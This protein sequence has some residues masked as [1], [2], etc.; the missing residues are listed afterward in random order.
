MYT[1]YFNRSEKAIKVSKAK[2]ALQNL[3]FT[4]EVSK[5]NNCY[6]ICSNRN[7]LVEKAREIKKEWILELEDDLNTVEA[8]KI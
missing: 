7:P 2:K 5:Y 3:N 1:L 6:F 4:E 8:I